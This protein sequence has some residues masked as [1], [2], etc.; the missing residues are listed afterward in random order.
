MRDRETDTLKKENEILKQEKLAL[1]ATVDQLTSQ[2]LRLTQETQSATHDQM[3][4]LLDDWFNETHKLCTK[5]FTREDSEETQGTF[6]NDVRARLLDESLHQVIKL[7][8]HVLDPEDKDPE[9]K[10]LI[11]TF[12]ALNTEIKLGYYGTQDDEVLRSHRS[13]YTDYI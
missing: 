3:R 4:Q 9:A 7:W 12:S 5:L 6:Y 1:T 8:Y 2:N 13:K 10:C 11:E